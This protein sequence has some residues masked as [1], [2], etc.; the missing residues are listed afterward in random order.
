LHAAGFARTECFQE[1]LTKD[2][3][4]SLGY[5]LQDLGRL[6]GTSVLG[7]P[8]RQALTA[9]LFAPMRLAARAGVA[10]RF[11]AVAVA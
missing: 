10:D 4:R 5:V 8:N 11:H 1:V 2:A 9:L 7:M 6:D 3:A